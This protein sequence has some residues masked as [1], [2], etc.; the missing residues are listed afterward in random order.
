MP[1]E[2]IE[3]Y[4]NSFTSI[5]LL[6][7]MTIWIPILAWIQLNKKKGVIEN[8]LIIQLVS[9]RG[10][11]ATIIFLLLLNIHWVVSKPDEKSF[12]ISLLLDKSGSMNTKDINEEARIIKLNNLVFSK[13]GI[14]DKIHNKYKTLIYGFDEEIKSIPFKNKSIVPTS[15][16]TD[17]DAS[18]LSILNRQSSET[19][20]AV[21]IVTDGNDNVDEGIIKAGVHFQ[22]LGIPISVIGIGSSQGNGD[23]RIEAIQ[24]P[25]SLERGESGI[26][27][28]LVSR[29]RLE[30]MEVKAELF[31]FGKLIKTKVVDLSVSEQKKISFNISNYRS[32]TVKYQTAITILDNEINKNNNVCN[33]SISITEPKIWKT[34]YLG[35]ALNWEYK[36]LNNVI[37]KTEGVV[38]NA[39]ILKDK[40]SFF[41]SGF[42]K[43]VTAFPDFDTLKNYHALIIDVHVFTLIQ[44]ELLEGLRRYMNRISGGILILGP[45][46]GDI[47]NLKNVKDILPITPGPVKRF[48]SKKKIKFHRTVFLSGVEEDEFNQWSEALYLPARQFYQK[49]EGMKLGAV[50]IMDLSLSKNSLMSAHHYG[51]CKVGYLGFDGTWQWVMKSDSGK[52]IYRSFWQKIISWLCSSSKPPIDVTPNYEQIEMGKTITL[53]AKVLNEKYLLTDKAKVKIKIFHPDETIPKRLTMKNDSQQRGIYIKDLYLGKIGEYRYEVEAEIPVRV[54]GKSDQVIKRIF[55]GKIQSIEAGNELGDNLLKEDLLIDLARIT[56]GKY[57]NYKDSFDVDDLPISKNVRSKEQV[58]RLN[59][60]IILLILGLFLILM[61]IYLRRKSGLK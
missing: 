40:K 24:A 43:K 54:E 55:K 31:E 4:S 25:E 19:L 33:V 26:L 36:F 3:I 23:L 59:D 45:Y 13:D 41:A 49:I 6:I 21:L 28:Y 32:G 51:S 44:D 39:I 27:Q 35:T 34:L 29:E 10:L 48:K 18:I 16:Q 1:F 17:I 12:S 37:N 20:G 9:L 15:K 56:G 5:Y 30:P 60:E 22:E 11:I 2:D 46:T 42:D 53:Q 52:R 50:S 61:E 57:W 58:Y 7:L 47:N 8:K 38:L 14:K